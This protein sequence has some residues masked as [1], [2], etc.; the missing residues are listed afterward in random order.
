MGRICRWVA[1][2]GLLALV[3]GH[4]PALGA[5]IFDDFESSEGHFTSAPNAASSSNSNVAST[6]TA[7]RV[8]TQHAEP[9]GIAAEQVVLKP[10]TAGQSMRVRF[11]SGGGTPGN[12]T[13]FTTSS[14][15]SDGYIG[16]A[17]KT[18]TSGWS[19][20]VVLDGPVSGDIQG[21]L[22]QS[23]TPDGE[24]HVYDWNL[25]NAASW[26]SVGG[27]G[28]DSTFD[29]GTQ[30]IDSIVFR[31]SAA[32]ASSTLF[33]DFVA[34]SDNGSISAIVPEPT[35]GAVFVIVTAIAAVLGGRRLRFS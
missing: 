19:V 5:I 13:A 9:L 31:H 15:T 8:T 26:G 17:I 32:P 35:S 14:S 33:M 16:L 34:K 3:S 23:I 11:L 18:S 28:G 25:D 6:S 29:E 24:W 1:I 21:G 7:D 30:S 4:S 20:Q 10:P 2:A 12:N 27:I 22:S